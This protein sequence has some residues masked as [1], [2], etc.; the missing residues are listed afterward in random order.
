MAVE[1]V[2]LEEVRKLV[3][4]DR[5]SKAMATAIG[6]TA[7][8]LHSEIR[9]LVF[10][11]YK[12]KQEKIDA[13][14]ANKS[15]NNVIFGKNI[16]SSDLTYNYTPNGLGSF[17]SSWEF[18]NINPGKVPGTVFSV[19]VKRGSKKIVYG[20]EH[21]GGFIPMNQAGKLKRNKLGGYNMYERTSNRRYP[22][23]LL[24]APSVSQMVNTVIKDN[25]FMERQLTSFEN[26]LKDLL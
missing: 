2:G 22:L 6:V 7:K 25:E 24:F 3:S 4:T 14:L 21:R 9:H 17:Y 18:G 19:E 23:R 12:I 1:I 5:I 26:R 16:I 11:K 10:T 13:A 15:I 20:K 8:T